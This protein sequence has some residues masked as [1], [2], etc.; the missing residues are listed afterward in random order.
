M[1]SVNSF[2]GVDL[3]DLT[4]GILTATNLLEGNNLLCFVFQI[5]KTA[6][7]N[8]L[9]TLFSILDVP[10]RLL[11]ETLSAS[12]LNINCPAFDDLTIGGKGF[13]QAMYDRFPGAKAANSAL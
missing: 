8:S 10:L 3:G 2:A 1:G 9:S 6:A 7:P 4:G 5:I 13:S 12:L 11:T